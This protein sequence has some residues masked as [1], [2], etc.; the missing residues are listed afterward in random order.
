MEENP[1][2]LN[3]QNNTVNEISTDS[4]PGSPAS[5]TSSLTESYN[6]TS[7][8]SANQA[9]RRVRKISKSLADKC[10]TEEELQMLR[11]KINGR[12]RK[13]MH[14]L[15]SALDGLREVMPYAHGPSVR[16]LSKI[17][18]LLLARNYILMLNNSLEEMKKLIS[19]VY[20]S[21]PNRMPI[22]HPAVPHPPHAH[23]PL[24]ITPG[25]ALA[26]HSEHFKTA[27]ATSIPSSV[28]LPPPPPPS[29]PDRHHTSPYG[30][31]HG[32]PS[33]PCTCAQCAFDT[34]RVSYATMLNGKHP[35]SKP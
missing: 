14:D 8:V 27:P 35:L 9:L 5:S 11:L 17:A 10:A 15:N 33:V 28:S 31:W 29:L 20:S 1:M 4:G 6:S 12:E 3:Q 34:V 30:P 23:L 7:P 26:P 19:D 16:K 24:T 32:I 2:S 21:Q 25:A 13:R 22:A 18:T